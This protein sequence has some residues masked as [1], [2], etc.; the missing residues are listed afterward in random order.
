M[1]QGASKTKILYLSHTTRIENA[2]QILNSGYIYTELDAILAKQNLQGGLLLSDKSLDLSKISLKDYN[3]ENQYPGVYMSIVSSNSVG[4]KVTGDINF[5]F[6]KTLLN[7]KDWHFNKLDSEGFFNADNTILKMQDLQ[8]F[9]NDGG[10]SRPGEIIFHHSVPINFISKINCRNEQVANIFYNGLSDKFKTVFGPLIQVSD[11]IFYQDLECSDKVAEMTPNY[12]FVFDKNFHYTYPNKQGGSGY[13]APIE[14]YRWMATQCGLTKDQ[15]NRVNDPA[16]LNKML[17]P[18]MYSRFRLV[19]E[20]GFS[21]V[22]DQNG[23][24]RYI[25]EFYKGK[26]FFRKITK[27]KLE[28]KIA[29]IIMANSYPNIVKIYDV[30]PNK[31][32]RSYTN[33]DMEF[34]EFNFGSDFSVYKSRLE[35][36]KE[37][38]HKFG[39]AYMDWKYDNIGFSSDGTVKVFDFDA[40]ALYDTKTNV[41]I[42]TPT[43]KGYSWRNAEAAGMSTPTDIDNWIFNNMFKPREEPSGK[44]S[45]QPSS[46]SKCELLSCVIDDGR[47]EIGL[48]IATFPKDHYIFRSDVTDAFYPILWYSDEQV[49]RAYYDEGLQCRGFI[50]KRNIQLIN[51]SDIETIRVMLKDPSLTE[52]ERYAIFY[53][54]GVD[55]PEDIKKRRSKQDVDGHGNYMVFSPA[56]MLFPEDMETKQYA[57]R[58]F[59]KVVCKFGYD[60]WFIPQKSVID[61]SGG[62]F[63]SEEIM[64]CNPGDVLIHTDIKCSNT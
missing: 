51:L 45:Y 64:L 19:A 20:E 16:E 57:N 60:G 11:T 5:Y 35:K 29:K 41:F 22:I 46:E 40:S 30:S 63:F 61:G 18:L 27:N 38:F 62:H 28:I 10:K 25:K 24:F 7:R 33:I 9:I 34:L 15:V 49:A 58:K 39:I 14:Y 54:T 37:F 53:V 17:I 44:P 47:D 32:D 31:E 21:V 43:N 8:K 55:A 26:R 52:R 3:V 13:Y 59:A 23:E 50:S 48:K 36:A 2:I 12:C 6:C 42:E 56:G 1:G 4:E